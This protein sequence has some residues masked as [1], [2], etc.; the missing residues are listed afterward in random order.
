MPLLQDLRGG[1]AHAQLA[2][3]RAQAQKQPGATLRAP[4]NRCG[5]PLPRRWLG[6]DRAAIPRDAFYAPY[7][8]SRIDRLIQAGPRIAARDEIT[9][10][11]I[12]GGIHRAIP[13]AAH[14][15]MSN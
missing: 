12:G 11:A 3:A 6:V 15:A 9:G 14:Q 5:K 1:L 2:N 8:V 4:Q 7:H 13:R 10:G